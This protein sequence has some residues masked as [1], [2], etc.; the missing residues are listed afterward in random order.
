M[1][2]GRIQELQPPSWCRYLQKPTTCESRQ[3]DSITIVVSMLRVTGGSL[4][5]GV[6]RVGSAL[7]IVSLGVQLSAQEEVSPI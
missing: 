1:S 3:H 4:V 5:G 2:F 6:L 7:E